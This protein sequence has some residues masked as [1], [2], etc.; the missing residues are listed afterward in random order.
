[1]EDIIHSHLDQKRNQE[2]NILL[3]L[4]MFFKGIAAFAAHHVF[5]SLYKLQFCYYNVIF[6]ICR[7]VLAYC[8]IFMKKVKFK[9]WFYAKWKYLVW[10]LIAGVY[11]AGDEVINTGFIEASH[12]SH[13]N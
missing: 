10:A 8:E 5:S 1:M 11:M 3:E 7:F 2:K 12:K 4:L 6:V 13:I 9:V